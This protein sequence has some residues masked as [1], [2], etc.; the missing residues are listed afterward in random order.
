MV[1][2]VAMEITAAILK[3]VQ[4]KVDS[5]KIKEIK[6]NW[7]HTA[8]AETTETPASANLLPLMSACAT[9]FARDFG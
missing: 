7:P 1:V 2:Y 3:K 8:G 4:D 5:F 6:C 9:I